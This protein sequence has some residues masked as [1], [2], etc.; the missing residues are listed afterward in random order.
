MKSVRKKYGALMY[1]LFEDGRIERPAQFV[2]YDDGRTI[3]YKH[4]PVV[5]VTTGWHGFLRANLGG[6]VHFVHIEI[7][8]AFIGACAYVLHKDGNKLNNR[9]DNLRSATW[10]EV[11]KERR[12][13]KRWRRV[14]PKIA[15][16]IVELRSRAMSYP[17]IS[18]ATGVNYGSVAK[19]ANATPK[20]GNKKNLVIE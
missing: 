10:K 19:I 3:A 16:H 17:A 5:A 18:A 4:K 20:M 15:A 13:Y 12:P 1:D 11:L 9:V 6:K 14:D 7:A 2:R 8:K